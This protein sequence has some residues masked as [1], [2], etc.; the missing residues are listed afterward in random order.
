MLSEVA[1]V[2][3]HFYFEAYIFP[4][5]SKIIDCE[6]ACASRAD[7]FSAKDSEIWYIWE[8]AGRSTV[9]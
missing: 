9:G 3:G 4:T 8:A 5:C 2:N 6:H 7:V 1:N